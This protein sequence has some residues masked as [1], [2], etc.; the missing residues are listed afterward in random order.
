MA[1]SVQARKDGIQNLSELV[2][3][4]SAVDHAFVNGLLQNRVKNLALPLYSQQDLLADG[5][6]SS[7]AR[8]EFI[9]CTDERILK[10]LG[11]VIC[12]SI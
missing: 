12:K 11:H 2:R 9:G 3:V 4:M 8:T 1:S 10:I 7:L 5:G 6:R